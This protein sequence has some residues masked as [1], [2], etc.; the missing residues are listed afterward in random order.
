MIYLLLLLLLITYLPY[1]D[2]H[3]LSPLDCRVPVRVVKD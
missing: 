2:S 1:P 3:A